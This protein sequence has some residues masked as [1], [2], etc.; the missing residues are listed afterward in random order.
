MELEKIKRR[1]DLA[2]DSV[3]QLEKEFAD[4]QQGQVGDLHLSSRSA[5]LI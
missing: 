2:E 1:I 5:M 4:L 3:R